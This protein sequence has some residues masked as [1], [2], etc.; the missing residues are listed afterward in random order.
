MPRRSRRLPALFT[1]PD[2]AGY[3]AAAD[4]GH[5]T[6]VSCGEAILKGQ[7]IRR[8]KDGWAHVACLLARHE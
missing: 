4:G 6:E 7:M 8:W 3:Q 1:E 5:C 2:A